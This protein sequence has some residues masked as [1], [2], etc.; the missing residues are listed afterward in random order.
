MQ[1]IGTPLTP[2]IIYE[3]MNEEL[4]DL[5]LTDGDGQ[6]VK[7]EDIVEIIEGYTGDATPDDKGMV[8][9]LYA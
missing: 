3:Q 8:V 5:G 9:H 2:A 1:A 7:A 4:T 6:P